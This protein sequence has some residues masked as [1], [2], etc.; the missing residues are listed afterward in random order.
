MKIRESAAL[1]KQGD[2]FIGN[3]S[4]IG[5]IAASFGVP[6]LILLIHPH[7]KGVSRI[8]RD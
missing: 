1:I 8:I 3:D 6:S 7:L 5:H 2:M 4:S